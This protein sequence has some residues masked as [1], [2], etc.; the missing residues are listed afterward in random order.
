[1]SLEENH[2]GKR[3]KIIALLLSL[4]PV[5][6]MY[7]T[8]LIGLGLSTTLVIIGSLFSF[9]IFITRCNK[10]YWKFIIPIS[11]YLIYTIVKSVGSWTNF[12][13]YI[14]VLLNIITFST[15]IVDSEALKKYIKIVSTIAAMAVIIQTLLYYVFSFHIPLI[16]SDFC[17]DSMKPYISLIKKGFGEGSS[18]Y[19]PSAFF[20]EPAHFAQYTCIG[21][22]FC[23]INDK[24]DYKNALIIS[25]GVLLT[26]SGIGVAIVLFIWAWLL[27]TL[28]KSSGLRRRIRILFSAF[29]IG[30]IGILFALQLSSVKIAVAR[31]LGSNYGGFTANQSSLL[32]RTLYWDKYISSLSG[33]VLIFGKGVLALPDVY[34]T[35]LM[36][37]I[38]SCGIVGVVLFY[39]AIIRFVRYPSD[40]L[41]CVALLYGGLMIVA[42]INGSISI[43][44]YLGMML[45]LVAPLQHKSKYDEIRSAETQNTEETKRLL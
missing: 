15:D 40:I 31:F 38:Y 36:T 13:L 19:R 5:L 17:M 9:L 39:F 21:L 29:I 2:E 25:V 30:F 1:M 43:L 33:N 3:S 14:A 4:L 7:K 6:M 12:I 28:I 23:L 32:G 20:L 34:F 27:L 41:R 37:I 11:V 24:P 35:G 45:V 10:V 26:T 16:V 22:S 44:F 8:P 42:N 18:F